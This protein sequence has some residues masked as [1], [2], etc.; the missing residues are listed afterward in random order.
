[1]VKGVRLCIN[2]LCLMWSMEGRWGRRRKVRKLEKY[3]LI[4]ELNKVVIV[5]CLF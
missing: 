2:D 3:K 5:Y 4:F 1:M